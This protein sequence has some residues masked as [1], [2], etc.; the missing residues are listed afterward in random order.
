[1][2]HT[3]TNLVGLVFFRQPPPP[4]HTFDSSPFFLWQMDSSHSLFYARVCVYIYI[5]IYIYKIII[6]ANTSTTNSKNLPEAFLLTIYK[7]FICLSQKQ[8]KNYQHDCWSVIPFPL[9]YFFFFKLMFTG[10]MVGDCDHLIIGIV[11]SLIHFVT[12]TAKRKGQFN[13]NRKCG[14]EQHIHSLK[15]NNSFD[16]DYYL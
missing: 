11:N 3:Y 9:I 6:L 1:M 15:K 7:N 13:D 4:S 14:A 2:A 8:T 10:F 12:I 5:Y 16:D